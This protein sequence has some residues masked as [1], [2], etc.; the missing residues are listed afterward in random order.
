MARRQCSR[1]LLLEVFVEA[2]E[3]R[4]ALCEPRF[5][6]LAG[7]ADACDQ[8][9]EADHLGADELRILEV[10]VVDDLGDRLER[11]ISE[12]EPSQQD[13]ESAA[14]S[15]VSVLR[16]EHVEAD[17]TRLWAVSTSGNES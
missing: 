14:I 6:V 3:D 12:L 15:F 2:V 11:G 1:S 9:V 16:L 8:A 4:A 7:H 5:V 17:F 13:L 10:D